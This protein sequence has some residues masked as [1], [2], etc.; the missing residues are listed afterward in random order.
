MIE[1]LDK[2]DLVKIIE[3]GMAG[4]MKGRIVEARRLFEGLCAYDQGL[5]PAK[6]GLA[7]CHLFTDEFE[8]AEEIL[9]GLPQDDDVLGVR[10]L[11]S[12]LKKDSAQAK[13]LMSEIKDR[14]GSGY[15]LASD[16]IAFAER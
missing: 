5:V 1:F 6:T 2:D 15:K 13:S 7:L 14:S 8:Q 3:I 12:V 11:A 16:T 4:A 10:V 9:D